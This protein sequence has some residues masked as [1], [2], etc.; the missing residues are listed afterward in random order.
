MPL[1]PKRLFDGGTMTSRKR[2]KYTRP[3]RRPLVP[4]VKEFLVTILADPVLPNAIYSV[5]VNNV[6]QGNGG[7]QRLGNRIK[8]LSVELVGNPT[9]NEVNGT[10]SIVCPKIAGDT[11]Q[12]TYF[13]DSIGPIYDSD[14]GWTVLSFTKGERGNAYALG[15]GECIRYFAKGM[16]VEF[17]GTTIT[18]NQ[19]N[20]VIPNRTGLDLKKCS[21]TIRIRFV[22]A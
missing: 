13:T 19:L 11:P 18:K 2:A 20:F 7:N 10:A 8:M 17:D 15:R 16:D 21:A 3:A 5:L 12:L 1:T 4:E 22:D 14:R 6:P 9:G